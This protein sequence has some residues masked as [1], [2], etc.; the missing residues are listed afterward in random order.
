MKFKN[1]P[2]SWGERGQTAVEYILLFSVVIVMAISFMKYVKERILGNPEQCAQ[3][4]AQS[5]ITC[6]VY[7]IFNSYQGS[8][9]KFRYFRIL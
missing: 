6:Q 1:V 5:S 3:A 2:E 8:Y 9:S 4:G 7:G